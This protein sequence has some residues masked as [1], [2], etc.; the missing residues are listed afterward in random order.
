LFG[1]TPNRIVERARQSADKPGVPT[2]GESLLF[3]SLGFFGASLFVFATVAFAGY[4]MYEHLGEGLAYAVWAALFILAG[5]AALSRLV[6]GPGALFRFYPLF[7]LAFFLYAAGWVAAYFPLRD[8]RGEWLGSLAGT[9]LIAVVFAWGFGA[10]RALPKMAIALFAS[11]SAGY[12]LGSFLN[13]S[14]GGRAGMMLW[15]ASYGWLFGLGLGYAI[16][17]A[18]RE[19]R[20]ALTNLSDKR[21]DAY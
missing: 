11:H 13:S 16:Y 1:L 15:G 5:G 6:I 7:S 8:A 9:L 3:G 2:V 18:Q 20:H 19:A 12:F 10:W 14:I 4:W 17:A 21:A